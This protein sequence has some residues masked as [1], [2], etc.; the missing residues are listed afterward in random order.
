MLGQGGFDKMNQQLDKTMRLV[1]GEKKTPRC[2]VRT[3]VMLEDSLAATLANKETKKKMSSTNSKA[4]NAM[5]QRLKKHNVSY[6][7]AIAAWRES[8][9]SDSEEDDDES[10]ESEDDNIDV[11][12]EAEPEEDEADRGKSK[13][14]KAFDRE[15]MK[16]P[17]K[18]TYA[19]VS[20][21]LL[22]I[23]AS[24][25][26]KGVDRQEQVDQLSYLARVAQTPAQA[27]EVMTAVV[28]AQFDLTPSM[29]THMPVEVWRA[30]VANL[31]QI[32]AI[33]S[34][35]PNIKMAD[36]IDESKM[37]N[38]RLDG[39]GE[40]VPLP[41]GE[42]DP[43]VHV[44]GN[45]VSF[46]E[47]L[48]DELFKSLQCID[49]H[50]VQYMDRLRDELVYISLAQASMSYCV[51]VEDGRALAR[52]LLRVLEHIYYKTDAVYAATT[53]I[54]L[55]MT[56]KVAEEAAAAKAQGAAA[57]EQI[58]AQEADCVETT[59]DVPILPEP[60]WFKLSMIESEL[61][62]TVAGFTKKLSATI[63]KLGDER[64]KARC[65]LCEIYAKAL[66]GNFHRARDLL[67]MSHMQESVQQMDVA[68]Q[69]LFNRAMAQLG[70]SAFHAGLIREGHSCLSELFIGGRVKEL[71]AQGV[72]MQRFHERD[73][74]KEKLERRRQMPFHMHINLEL[75][76]AVHLICAMLLEVSNM[77][78][79]AHDLRGKLFS[80]PLRRLLDINSRQPF[81][82]PPENVRD[83]AVVATLALAKGDWQT[84]LDMLLSLNAWKLLPEQQRVE[85]LTMLKAK[86][87]EEALRTY[88]LTYATYYSSLSLEQ[89][90]SMFELSEQTVHSLVS[91]AMLSGELHASWDQPTRSI[92]MHNIEPT[93]LQRM[94]LALSEKVQQLAEANERA[95]D[96]TGGMRMEGVDGD[97]GGDRRSGGRG[98][99]G[100]RGRGDYGGF[101]G[102][103]NGRGG[104]GGG[105]GRGRGWGG[106][107]RRGGGVFSGGGGFQDRHGRERYGYS[108]VGA[109]SYAERSSR[110][111]D[112]AA[113][114]P[115]GGF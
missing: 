87:Q 60:E 14:Q 39:D 115:F 63:Y 32:F 56:K 19:M 18:V 37:E 30:C 22:E 89:L 91:K 29:A 50:T 85:T 26:K 96:S 43:E 41:E 12:D 69:I 54:H 21:K 104:R 105:R 111:Q 113:R 40:L 77:A 94:A 9:R 31:H 100:G 82:G 51:T 47:R 80:K 59:G 15:F 97:D 38:K 10:D 90:C 7:A 57:A 3:L 49:P 70:L 25:G 24:R 81:T 48:D 2:Y 84:A 93:R 34:S 88:L 45:L 6:E 78:I 106:A 33:L 65:M 44:H 52:V 53:R 42:A 8:P 79:N 86:V 16:D 112:S 66:A 101:G 64:T 4:L 108:N 73:P 98:G 5:R 74:E 110:Y 23:S 17:T 58:A 28:S 95:V 102:G 114:V 107:G 46:L 35:Y 103:G 13:S 36:V 76:E 27:L 109:F 71:L 83:H 20:A 75:L 72:S 1:Q 68:T 67:L 61:P 99:R 55:E 62:E 92:V 11:E